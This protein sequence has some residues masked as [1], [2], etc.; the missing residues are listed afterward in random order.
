MKML[1]ESTKSS[2]ATLAHKDDFSTSMKVCKFNKYGHCKFGVTCRTMHVNTICTTS[3]C[4]RKTCSFRHPKHCKF[5][6]S[7]GFCKFGKDCS[8]IHPDSLEN[9][10][11]VEE[12]ILEM[13][14][15]LRSLLST[16]AEKEIRIKQLEEKVISIE[17]SSAS[18]KNYFECEICQFAAS[19]STGLKSHIAQIHNN[20]TCPPLCPPLS[21]TSS[22]SK[23]QITVGPPSYP[24]PKSYSYQ[25]CQ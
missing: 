19:S 12:D 14:E 2:E 7:S 25:F 9:K 10:S 1:P 17:G 24:V 8:Y 13:K 20:K 16:L 3:D 22:P 18:I 23:K 4:N 6:T 15:T 5:F 21:H 11:N